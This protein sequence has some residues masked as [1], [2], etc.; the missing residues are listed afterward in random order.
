MRVVAFVAR[1]VGTT[2][3]PTSFGGRRI[4]NQIDLH[5]DSPV[6]AGGSVGHIRWKPFHIHSFRFGLDIENI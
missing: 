5:E 1:Y 4:V 3:I 6:A 2:T